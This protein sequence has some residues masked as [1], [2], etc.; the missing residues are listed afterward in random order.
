MHGRVLVGTGHSQRLWKA[1]AFGGSPRISLEA[2]KVECSGESATRPM[3][4][5]GPS[6]WRATRALALGS[7]NHDLAEVH[8]NA[9]S[10]DPSAQST[11]ACL[12]WISL[13]P[14]VSKLNSEHHATLKAPCMF[15][16]ISPSS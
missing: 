11:A 4:V 7:Y 13:S 15:R 12:D 10:S 8:L 9:S 14:S 3:H 6:L 5:R 16:H 2:G 1:P